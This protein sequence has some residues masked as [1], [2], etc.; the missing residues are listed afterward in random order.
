MFTVALVGPDGAGKTTVAHELARKLPLPT[1]Y[2]YMGVAPGSSNRL[3]PTTWVVHALRRRRG[4]PTEAGPAGVGRRGGGARSLLRLA[5]RVAEESYRQVLAW[6]HRAR[7]RVV[8]FD[9]HFFAD[10]YS[11]D[12]RE[13][14]SLARRLH[15]LFLARV[16]PKPDLVVYLDA[17]AALLLARKGEGT[18]ESLEALRRN[19]ERL[20]E[21]APRFV[22]V[23]ASQPLD[24]VVADA[25]AAI[26]EFAENRGRKPLTEGRQARAGGIGPGP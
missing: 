7:G 14:T 24:A 4:V 26:C 25:S 22:R 2:L 13:A 5:N 23:D 19:Y 16:Y 1:T 11:T 17:P 8:L 9:R 12:V 10:Y 18:L 3:L 21:A 20:A 15:G 6:W